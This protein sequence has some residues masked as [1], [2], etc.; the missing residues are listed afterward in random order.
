MYIRNCHACMHIGIHKTFYTEASGFPTCMIVI[1][2]S[3]SQQRQ[4]HAISYLTLVEILRQRVRVKGPRV[5]P[6]PD[7]NSRIT[8]YFRHVMK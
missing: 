6:K 4:Y 7:Y 5:L 2:V 8:F 3:S 1:V